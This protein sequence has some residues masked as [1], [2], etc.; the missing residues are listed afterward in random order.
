M[1]ELQSLETPTINANGFY[2][3]TA[4]QRLLSNPPSKCV[5]ALWITLYL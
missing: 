2:F 5:L 4:G 1:Q 3:N